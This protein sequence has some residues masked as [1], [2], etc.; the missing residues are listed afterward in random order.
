MPRS[1]LRA[2]R[3][4]VSD[5]PSST[6]VMGHS[7][8]SWRT[9]TTSSSPRTE[10][11][12]SLTTAIA[13][14]AL[15]AGGLQKLHAPLHVEGRAHAGQRQSEL[16]EGDGPFAGE[17]AHA[18]HVLFTADGNLLIPDDGHRRSRAP[19]GRS[20]EAPCPAPR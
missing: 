3:T 4:P 11:C 20:P 2:V 5:S 10:T 13:G 19:R 16:H 8:A 17:L 15:L 7:R 1:T 6:R 9:R 18:H 12:S 14:L